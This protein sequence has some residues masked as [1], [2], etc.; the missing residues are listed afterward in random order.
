MPRVAGAAMSG[1][2]QVVVHDRA[3][4]E[5]ALAVADELDCEIWLRSA[6]DAAAYAGV[7]YLKALG[8]A[9]GYEI[10]VDCGDDAGIV[11]A[12][13]RAGA[14]RLAFSGPAAVSQRLG[15]VAAAL[16]AWYRH[17]TQAP[18]VLHLSP[19]DDVRSRCRAW[20]HDAPHPGSSPLADRKGQ[21]C[22]SRPRSRR[23]CPG[24]RARV[25]GSKATSPDYLMHG[26]LAGTEHGPARSFASNPPAYD[27]L[28]GG[29]ATDTRG[30]LEEI[31][32]IRDGGA[33]GSIIGRNSFKRPKPE[34]LAPLD[35]V[36]QISL[37]EA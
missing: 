26:R 21:P 4:A 1:P 23:S 15:E 25:Q 11:M 20:L 34:A 5:A 27:Q 9:L 6:P 24:T 7:G 3:Q 14:R 12:A 16:G 17:E 13:L 35:E 33:T 29:E 36:V 28:S 22:S 18:A 10:V 8:D 32:Q 37:N 2:P 31:R 19:E 30:F